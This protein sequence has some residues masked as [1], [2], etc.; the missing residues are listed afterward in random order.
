VSLLLYGVVRADHKDPVGLAGAGPGATDVRLIRSSTLAAAVSDIDEVA[1]ADADAYTYLDVLTALLHDGPVLPVRFGTYGPDDNAI[2]VQILDYAASELTARLDALQGL[3]EVRIN[4]TADEEAELRLL[5]ATS[6]ALAKTVRHPSETFSDLEFSI[7]VGEAV[8]RGLEERRAALQ[9]SVLARLGDCAVSEA[10]CPTDSHTRLSHAF[11]LRQEDLP[12]FDEAVRLF[13]ED[14]PAWYVLEYVGPL[15]AVDFL[16]V[17]LP[18]P[19]HAPNR[20]GW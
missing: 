14:L 1:L 10:P 15:P 2:R 5:L 6:P 7:E 18:Q 4:I 20:W 13:G 9:G 16:K 12:A 19:R 3:V 8:S 17:A 11:L